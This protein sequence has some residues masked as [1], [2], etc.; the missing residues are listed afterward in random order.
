MVK[1]FQL[2][3]KILFPVPNISLTF[4]SNAK[5]PLPS[6]LPLFSTFLFVDFKSTCGP[7]SVASSGIKLL[8]AT[9]GASGS[10][11]VSDLVPI[12]TDDAVFQE[13]R[14]FSTKFGPYIIFPKDELNTLLKRMKLPHCYIFRFLL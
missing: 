2:F 10:D 9:S 11:S 14:Q 8:S 3:P 1:P 7:S 6:L 13:G 4:S 5:L 12:I